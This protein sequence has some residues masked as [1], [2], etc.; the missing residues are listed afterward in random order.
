MRLT[1]ISP[2]ISKKHYRD[3]LIFLMPT[4]IK[5]HDYQITVVLVAV[6]METNPAKP[7]IYYDKIKVS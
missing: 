7:L 3:C 6:W 5:W 2:A 4:E 1:E